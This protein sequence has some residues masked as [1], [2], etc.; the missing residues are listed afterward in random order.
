VCWRARI[1]R[2]GWRRW[3]RP[4]GIELLAAAAE[5]AITRAIDHRQ[6]HMTKAEIQRD[7]GSDFVRDVHRSRGSNRAAL[8]DEARTVVKALA[9]IDQDRTAAIVDRFA[10]RDRTPGGDRRWLRELVT[11]PVEPQRIDS[12]AVM[13]LSADD[14]YRVR[15]EL[16]NLYVRHL[17]ARRF[18]ADDD[19][20]RAHSGTPLPAGLVSDLTD[21][22][23]A[24]LLDTIARDPAWR[25]TERFTAA[26]QLAVFRDPRA[27]DLLT[28]LAA[29]DSL[30][31]RYRTMAAMY[32]TLFDRDL[33]LRT[34]GDIC[35][36]PGNS[37][38]RLAAV[39][40]TA[41]VDQAWAQR[42]LS[43]LEQQ[44]Q[45]WRLLR[46]YAIRLARRSIAT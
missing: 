17:R 29:N 42:A 39:E 2:P 36:G 20:E 37:F 23:S 25:D 16:G 14:R 45:R 32:L 9:A 11:A 44:T 43:R 6:R 21:P 24:E 34:L 12:A 41:K 35:D 26:V 28:A 10:A 19:A 7:F 15:R 40:R 33:A 5:E 22:G 27:P 4:L 1:D 8:R 30:H 46:R 3:D 18:G 13:P 38:D 31:V